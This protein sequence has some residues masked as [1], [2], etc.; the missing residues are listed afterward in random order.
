MLFYLVVAVTSRRVGVELFQH[1]VHVEVRPSLGYLPVFEPY[2]ADSHDVDSI[3][4]RRDAEKFA[5]LRPDHPSP[6]GDEIVLGDGSL[7]IVSE[8]GERGAVVTNE[9]L[10]LVYVLRAG[11]CRIVVYLLLRQ[12]LVH[13]VYVTLTPNL[14][15][16][17]TNDRLVPLFPRG[18]SSV[19]VAR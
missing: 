12:Y 19:Y 6:E 16:V 7:D 3:P 5:L 2:D 18:H 13:D 14:V 10:E 17:P 9:L 8:V 11:E 4:G 15:G 1:A